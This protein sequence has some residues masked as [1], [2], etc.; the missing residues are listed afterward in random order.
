MKPR[1]P[2]FWQGL[3]SHENTTDLVISDRPRLTSRP[4]VQK[5]SLIVLIGGRAKMAALHELFGARRRQPPGAPPGSSTGIHLHVAAQSSFH[6]RPLL[7][8]EGG[9][10]DG[11]S[12]AFPPSYLQDVR[13]RTVMRQ[14][15]QAVRGLGSEALYSRLLEP[16]ADVFCYFCDDLGGL[17]A[18]ARH[19]ATWPDR[20]PQPGTLVAGARPKI[21]IVSSAIPHGAQS[22]SKAKADLLDMARVSAAAHH[23][24]LKE[25]VM[26]LSDEVRR[27]RVDARCLFSVTHFAAFLDVACDHFAAAPGALFD[28]VL[29]AR[30]R[31]PV[32]KNLES[33]IA[34]FLSFV[35]S[36]AELID[37]A[38]PFFDPSDVFESLY[39]D[40]IHRAC[41]DAALAV[42]GEPA[43]SMPRSVLVGLVKARFVECFGELVHQSTTASEI[44]LRFLTR[45]RPRCLRVHSNRTCLSCVPHHGL[46]CGHVHCD[47][48]AWD[49]G[50][51]SDDDPWTTSR[52]WTTPGACR[53]WGGRCGTTRRCLG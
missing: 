39:H 15:P 48:C 25:R 7:I 31:S 2:T 42:A 26:S 4:D 18:V 5:P 9:L 16:F 41:S 37:F 12:K 30:Y 11:D 13:G 22:E 45:F 28:F 46:P 1:S 19:L 36:P 44:H 8:V 43:A 51:P 40:L 10:Q 29:G 6:E 3:S 33:H 34:N 27:H 35:N 38:A 52:C 32:P 53:R 24:A 17:E 21:A 20:E 47:H 50:R 49:Y 14:A 23:R